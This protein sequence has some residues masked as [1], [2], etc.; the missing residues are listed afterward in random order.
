MMDVEHIRA[1]PAHCCSPP[2]MGEM[3]VV[4]LPLSLN[5]AH[6]PLP[7]SGRPPASWPPTRLG[8]G[9]DL[10]LEP[11][12]PIHLHPSSGEDQ[13]K[14]DRVPVSSALPLFESRPSSPLLLPV[15]YRLTTCSS[16]VFFRCISSQVFACL[17]KRWVVYHCDRRRSRSGLFLR[18]RHLAV[19]FR[20]TPK[21]TIRRHQQSTLCPLSSCILWPLLFPQLVDPGPSLAGSPSTR[22][23]ISHSASP[24]S[25]AGQDKTPHSDEG[26]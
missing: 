20:R 18:K 26:R 23:P 9:L 1:A 11:R 19:S 4:G 22:P 12:K 16:V 10:C 24:P 15:L 17:V 6:Q 7:P 25:F 8:A 13:F 2:W 21:D 5:S 14:I 3:P